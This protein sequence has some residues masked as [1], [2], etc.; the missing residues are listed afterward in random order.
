MEEQR[1]ENIGW[2]I[3]RAWLEAESAEDG[4]GWDAPSSSGMLHFLQGC[5]ISSR[6]APSSPGMLHH[7]RGCSIPWRLAGSL[8]LQ[9]APH[10]ECGVGCNLGC[11]SGGSDMVWDAI[12]FGMW[13]GVQFG[14]KLGYV[15][16]CDS[17][18]NVV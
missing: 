12:P 3:F 16:G 2:E 13:C 1:A 7:L 18:Q 5:S 4:L 14:M 15:L 8:S 10:L 6:G 9:D 17:V 11:S